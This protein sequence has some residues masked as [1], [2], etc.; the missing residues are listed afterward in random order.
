MGHTIKRVGIDLDQTV[1][2][3]L[4]AAIPIMEET[5]GLK[6]DPTVRSKYLREVFGFSS[7]SGPVNWKKYLYEERNIFRHLPKL[8]NDTEKLTHELIKDVNIYIITARH[9]TPNLAGDTL[10]WLDSHGFEY[11]DVFLTDNKTDLCQALEI[12]VML[13]DDPKQISSLVQANF[14]VVVRNQPWNQHL[15]FEDRVKRTSHWKE[16]LEATKEFLT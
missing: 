3:F 2:D 16:M 1:A 7:D 9:N 12:D 8:E 15:V 5:Y 14:K 13:E 10:H 4:A 6:P 11:T